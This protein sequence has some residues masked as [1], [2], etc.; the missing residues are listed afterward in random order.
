M[1]QRNAPNTAPVETPAEPV[2]ESAARQ[3][4]AQRVVICGG[5]AVGLPL[6]I[7]LAHRNRRR[8]LKW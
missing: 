1:Q 2:A 6:A 4:G 5:G 7:M 8:D 3:A